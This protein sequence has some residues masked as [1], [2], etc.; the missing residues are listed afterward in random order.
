MRTRSLRGISSYQRFT[1]V[2]FGSLCACTFLR[3]C[4]YLLL[5]TIFRI[6][7]TFYKK[8]DDGSFADAVAIFKM[9]ET[10]WPEYF[11]FPVE[12]EEKEAEKSGEEKEEEEE[13]TNQ[14]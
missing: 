4:F 10:K 5:C 8:L 6:L 14:Q 12:G 11:C 1:T 3:L 9:A 2:S 13:R 7:T